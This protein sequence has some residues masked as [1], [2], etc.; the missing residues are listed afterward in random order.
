MAPPAYARPG[1]GLR[2]LAVFTGLALGVA[3]AAF[4]RPAKG[5][6]VPAGTGAVPASP[7]SDGVRELSAALRADQQA[8]LRRVGVWGA[9]NAASGLLLWALSDAETDPGRR[10]F[11][12]QT[13][14]WGAVNTGI[15]AAGLLR[16]PGET[17]GEW[18]AAHASENGYADVLLVNLGLNVG[19]AAV[20]GTLI[21][22]AGRGVPNPDAWRG[23]GAALVVQGAGLFVLDGIAYLASRRRMKGLTGRV[24]QVALGPAPD[25]ARLRVRF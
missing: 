23:H 1:A 11:A 13:A 25:G 8:H 20:G 17:T 4:A 14:A 6:A 7:A 12:M 16:G 9:T 21:A 10:G 5:Q 18:A 24:E 2:A 19:Y 15:A 3:A 22:A